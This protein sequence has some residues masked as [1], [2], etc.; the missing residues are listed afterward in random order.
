[1]SSSCIIFKKKQNK[2]LVNDYNIKSMFIHED[3][4][5][6]TDQLVTMIKKFS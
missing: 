4:R 6:Y 2:K 3:D 1:M 5:F